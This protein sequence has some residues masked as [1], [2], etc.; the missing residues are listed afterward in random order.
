MMMVVVHVDELL[1][2]L[3]GVEG[4]VALGKDVDDEGLG[5]SWTQLLGL[6]GGS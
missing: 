5:Y 2:D 3:V 4:G 1:S 6:I